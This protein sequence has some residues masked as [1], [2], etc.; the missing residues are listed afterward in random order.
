MKKNLLLFILTALLLLG[1]VACTYNPDGARQNTLTTI[2]LDEN[3]TTG[4]TWAVSID[5]LAVVRQFSDSYTPKQAP[6]GIVGTGGTHSYIFQAVSP[7]T[8]VITFE[9]GQQWNGGQKG[10]ETKKYTVTVN[11]DGTI[12]AAEM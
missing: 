11:Q 6:S 8:A 7:G 9:L 10:V 5:N 1:L 2:V 4:Y 12:L 3:P